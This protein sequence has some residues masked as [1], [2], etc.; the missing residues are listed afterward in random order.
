MTPGE[1]ELDGAM[2]FSRTPNLRVPPSA[3]SALFNFQVAGMVIVS[4]VFVVVR[5]SLRVGF[6]KYPVL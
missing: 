3:F 2:T 4:F 1:G 5:P 6:A